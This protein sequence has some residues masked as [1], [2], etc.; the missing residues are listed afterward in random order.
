MSSKAKNPIKMIPIT[1][2][3]ASLTLSS[4]FAPQQFE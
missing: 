1:G 4:F 2:F 3:F